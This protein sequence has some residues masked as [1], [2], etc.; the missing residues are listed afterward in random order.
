MDIKHRECVI[1]ATISEWGLQK[2]SEYVRETAEFVNLY[3]KYR[4]INRFQ[5]LIKVFD[6]LL[7]KPEIKAS[8][9]ELPE[10]DTLRKW[11]E[12]APRLGNNDL[13]SVV[14]KTQDPVLKR[15]LAWTEAVDKNLLNNIEKIQTFT[16][17]KE[18]L[19]IVSE[20]AEIMVVSSESIEILQAEWEKHGLMRFINKIAGRENGSKNDILKQISTNEYETD[21]ILMIGDAPGD[22]EAAI[23]NNLLFYPIN[24]GLEIGSWKRF[25]FEAFKKILI[26]QYNGVYQDKVVNVFKRL[27]NF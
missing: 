4:G 11:V 3:S 14:D 5:A 18:S 19:E 2:V 23:A 26:R 15:A 21:C 20:Y 22:L 16:F 8:G 10:I 13:K 7:E 17:V 12:S 6:L 1:P 25:H 24:P 9:V 27:M